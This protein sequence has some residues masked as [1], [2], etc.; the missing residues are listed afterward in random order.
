MVMPVA[1]PFRPD[2]ARRYTVDEV[3]AWAPD[4]NR[5]EVVH[6]ELLVTPSP[7]LPH[8]LV[9]TRIFSA[10]S[11]YLEQVGMPDALLPGPV[12]YFHGGDVYV[13]PDLVVAHPEEYTRDYR[14]MRHLRLAVEI[15]SPSS[16]RG[17][18]LVKRRAYQDAGVETYW[19][20]D[21]DAAVVEVWHPS[22]DIAQI[23]TRELVW[24]VT[25]EA[26]ELRIELA[27]L[28]AGLP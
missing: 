3:L 11:R 12:D 14:T 7:L 18:R 6:G 13:Q 15:V 16:A 10:L 8:Q 25:P 1:P 2:P 27:G 4:G 21:P 22:D 26:A 17:D 19:V 9:L 28:F 24:R 20:V 23:A 5:Y